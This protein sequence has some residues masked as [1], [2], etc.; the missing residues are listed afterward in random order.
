MYTTKQSPYGNFNSWFLITANSF[1][2][3]AKSVLLV[4][5]SHPRT[6]PSSV[7]ASLCGAQNFH[8]SY[9]QSSILH[10]DNNAPIDRKAVNYKNRV[11]TYNPSLSPAHF[12]FNRSISKGPGYSVNP[13]LC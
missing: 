4:T 13:M 10:H 11:W 6:S 5:L 9:L 1:C 8:G 3:T 2:I 7:F 12:H